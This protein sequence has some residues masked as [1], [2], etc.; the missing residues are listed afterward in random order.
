MLKNLLNKNYLIYGGSIVFSRGLEYAV[1]FFAAHHLSKYDYGELEYYKKVIEVVSSV[2]AF[3]FPALILSYTKSKESKNYFFLLGLLFV[4]FVG[5]ITAIFFS[6][7]NWLFLIVPFVFYAI[8]FTGGIA[9]S[10]FLVR[11]GST[12]AS[13]YKIIISILFYGVIFISIYY[14]DVTS[15][16]YVYVNYFLFPLSFIHVGALFYREKIVW[17]KIKTYWRLFKKLLL[18]SFT[19]VISNF[20]NL[21]FLYTDI[22]VIKLLSENSNVDIANYSFALNVANMLLLIPLTLVQVDIEKLKIVPNYLIEINK[23]ILVLVLVASLFLFGFY[24]ILVNNFFTDYSNTQNV[25]II[26]LLAKIFHSLST[27]YGTNLII[28]KKFK[29]NLYVNVAMLLLNIL[30][31]YLLY[32]QFDLIGVAFASLCSLL[33]RYFLLIYL[34]KNIAKQKKS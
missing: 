21:T 14:F 17:Q 22:F 24:L 3:G 30:L 15:Y 33:I 6:L 20:A 8:F 1:L 31:S 11:Q 9:Q 28:L 4:L 32:F 34:N 10:Y 16:A 2:F 25:F 13:Y 18:S 26:I 12:Y 27:L 29:E 19:L 5:A 7:F 23:K